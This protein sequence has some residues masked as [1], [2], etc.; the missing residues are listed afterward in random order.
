MGISYKE[1]CPD[2][3]NSQ[4]LRIVKDIKKNKNS[5]YVF[6]PQIMTKNLSLISSREK[7]KIYSEI[8][9]KN[10]KFDLVLYCLNHNNL[11]KFNIKN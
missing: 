6:D 11:K 1:N 7:F 8:K 9:N 4:I 2:I 3:R 5:V 10:I